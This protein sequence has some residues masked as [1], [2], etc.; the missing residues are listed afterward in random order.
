MKILTN[1]MIT[2][3]TD[4]RLVLLMVLV[5]QLAN[6]VVAKPAPPGGGRM[7]HMASM[8]EH[9]TG[10][11]KD[12]E[13][14]ALSGV[15]VKN[16][17]K[18]ATA[19]TDEH[20]RFSIPASAGDTLQFSSLGFETQTYVVSADR[21]IAVVLQLSTSSLDEVV[22]VGFGQQKKVNLTGSVGVLDNE[23][24][25]NRPVQNVTQAL[26]GLVPGLNI[27][28]ANGGSLDRRANINIRGVATIGEGSSGGALVLID[29]MEADLKT[30]NPQDI[31]SISVLKDAAAS[32]IYGSR[33]P[34][35]V[36]L[37]TTKKG[38]AGSPA[39]N[40]NNSFR[41]SS[42]ISM[43][44]MANS[45]RFATMF[46]DASVAA[47]WGDR[48]NPERMQR[49]LDYMEGRITA[50][51]V[52]NPGNPRL[53]GDGYDF[54]NDNIN[55]YDV[56]F[57]KNAPSQEHNVSLS[58][59]MNKINYYLS[60]NYLNQSGLLNYGSDSY[61]RFTATGK[62]GADVSD[63]LSVSY[64]VRFI[65]ENFER[66]R[67]LSDG[68]FWDLARQ[69]WPTKPLYDPN[70]HLF[71]DHVL[72]MD[73]GGRA[74]H[75]ED[76]L[77]QQLQLVVRP[78]EGMRMVG[79]VNYR[80]NTYLYHQHVLTVHQIAVDGVSR[81]NFWNPNTSAQESVVKN[82]YL[83]IN[84]YA[85]YERTFAEKH[86]TKF[87]VGA[88]AEDNRYRDFG[89]SR[90]GLMVPGLPAL[91]TTTGLGADGMPIPPSI[92]GAYSDW[93][94]VGI[95]GRL[96]Y[97]YDEKYL[98][99]ANLRYDGTSRF[100]SDARW[101]LF[102]S[103][104]AG[105]NIANEAFFEPARKHIGAL[106]LRAS[107]G[108]L[109]NQ[110]TWN[111]YPTYTVMNIAVASGP[112]L[113]N[114]L[115]PT[116][117]HAPG[118]ISTSLTWED[119]VTYN[120]GLD[121]EMF[122]GRLNFSADVYQR[123]T[124]NMVGPAPE[125]PVILGTPVP[126][127]NNT[128]LRTNGF[129]LELAWRDRTQRG[130]G[131]GARLLLSDSRTVITRYSNPTNS[132]SR[133]RVGQE[134]GEIWG[135]TTKGIART[136]QEMDEHLAALPNGGQGALGGYWDAGDIMYV[137]VN[138]DGKIDWGANT[139]DDSGDLRIIGN[140]SPRYSFGADLTADWKGIDVRLFFQGV[141]KRDMFQS[142]YYFWGIDGAQGPW[143]STVFDEHLDYFRDD[144]EHA[145]GLN[146]DAYYP[147]ALFGTGKNQQAQTRY[148]QDA[149][150]LRLK[151]AQIGY[152]F[153]NQ[154]TS[155]IGIKNFRISLSGENLATFTRL[156]KIF[157][158]ET[159]FG[160]TGGN[161]Y[162]LAKVWSFGLNANF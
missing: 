109:G 74:R 152:T 155:K 88:Q 84:A 67:H 119:I 13:G 24:L 43:P 3:L 151:N 62:V 157:D 93:A 92:W 97:N 20:G 154:L 134:M 86:Y 46:N 145:L 83:N 1:K 159:V 16:G 61:G 33:A 45:Y 70:G 114:G 125:L 101:G 115:Q 76:W 150:Y 80:T 136:K 107:Y 118:L 131:Y 23:A 15:T 36:I 121:M 95:F 37:I 29:G 69:A 21:D 31:E 85:D 42:P 11:V 87:M 142:S 141:L 65:R 7:V 28:N 4:Q 127:T 89:G 140:E 149:S 110:N 27:D 40:Y 53:W 123:N 105:W 32:S 106:K 44:N 104:S 35:G 96:N 129:E 8:Q 55:Y 137:D 153:P 100:R 60:S 26:Q 22:I 14:N 162:P 58:G 108:S 17:E 68:L 133:Y 111:I 147:R 99:E 103:F 148:L 156:T 139:A 52:P 25:Q 138:G 2:G 143:F 71:D 77:Y 161:V 54:G 132:L 38:K 48:F 47:G 128:D 81:G 146:L 102:P 78:T 98:F 75:E 49:I 18:S 51:T 112:W 126:V 63:K 79:E 90:V 41:Y 50:T 9:I 94:T 5:A 144:P 158:P 34:F 59:G 12:N 116:V 30:V 39:I 113:I 72:N 64:N 82:N 124:R 117:A 10:S 91:N 19:Q 56:F 6:C 66:P 130:L 120:G 57:R 122:G 73:R 135:Y 160:S